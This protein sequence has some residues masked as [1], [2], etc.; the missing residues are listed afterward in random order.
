MK[1]LIISFSFFLSVA[2]LVS[3]VGNK[4]WQSKYVQVAKNGALHYSPD[5]K[6]NE[7]SRLR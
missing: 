1:K 3:F 5:A 2:A 6:G 4:E 7:P